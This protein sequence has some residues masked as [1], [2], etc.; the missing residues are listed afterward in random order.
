MKLETGNWKLES[1]KSVLQRWISLPNFKFQVFRLGGSAR[2]TTS[3]KFAF[4]LLELLTVMGIMMIIAAIVVGSYFNM[5]RG[6][7]MRSALSHLRSTLQFARQTAIMNGKKTYVIFGQNSTNAWYVTCRHEGTGNGSGTAL[8][9]EYT[10]WSTVEKGTTIYNLDTGM[11][12]VITKI[13]PETSPGQIQTTNSIPSMWG[14]PGLHRYGWE[15][16]PR[17]YLPRGFQFGSGTSP[18]APPVTIIFNGDGTT[19]STPYEITIY[20]KIHPQSGDPHGKVVVAGLTGFV[21]DEVE[22]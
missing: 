19:R 22:E 13:P 1:R 3:F 8:T 5:T 16:H 14:A 7:G 17:T 2:G 12:S 11:N 9:D 15:I 6:A 18:G 21:S 20:E 10:D 4:T